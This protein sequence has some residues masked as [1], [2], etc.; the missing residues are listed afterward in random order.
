MALRNL[1]I[2]LAKLSILG[3]ITLA[4]IGGH[5]F[6]AVIGNE[7]ANHWY[8]VLINDSVIYDMPLYK[9]L[10]REFLV[11]YIE[12]NYVDYDKEGIA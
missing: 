10:N 5:V 11:K 7:L 6:G 3:S 4:T 8:V 12:E 1:N 9:F 2:K